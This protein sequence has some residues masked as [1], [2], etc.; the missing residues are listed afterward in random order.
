MHL[1][2]NR[3]TKQVLEVKRRRELSLRGYGRGVWWEREL[4]V[5]GAGKWE[6]GNQKWMGGACHSPGTG[7]G[8][9]VSTEATLRLLEV[10]Y[11]DLEVVTFSSWAGL[12][13]ER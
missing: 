7:G 10:A 6:G 1:S 3:K 8:P 13:V 5:W 12:Q 11:I 9:R 2:Q 4:D